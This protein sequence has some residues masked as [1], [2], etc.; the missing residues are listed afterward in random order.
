[1]S[2]AL[3]ISKKQI[4]RVLGIFVYF[5]SLILNLTLIYLFQLFWGILNPI[6]LFRILTIFILCAIPSALSS[7]VVSYFNQEQFEGF[8]SFL[9][10]IFIIGFIIVVFLSF[11]LLY[12]TFV[13]PRDIYEPLS[14]GGIFLMFIFF[15]LFFL[16][17]LLFISSVFSIIFG[18]LG[19][20]LNLYRNRTVTS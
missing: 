19:Y 14:R 4:I 10:S 1:M 9:Y 5:T 11:F 3:K 7:F 15:V 16:H 20:K 18:N 2:Y 8:R 17:P 6:D 12:V 13:P